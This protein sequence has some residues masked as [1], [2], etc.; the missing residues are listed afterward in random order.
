MKKAIL[1]SII[2]C[3]SFVYAED[4]PFLGFYPDQGTTD[5]LILGWV[6]WN[7]PLAKADIRTGDILLQIDSLKVVNYQD[8]QLIIKRYKPYQN[9]K[10]VIKRGE[11]ILEKTL[12]L[13]NSK[14]ALSHMKTGRKLN[15]YEITPF[16]KGVL[17]I[18]DFSERYLL[19]AINKAGADKDF[20]ILK[21]LFN[22]ELDEK[23]GVYTL[24]TFHFLFKNPLKVAPLAEAIANPFIKTSDLKEIVLLM[25]NLMDEEIIIEKKPEPVLLNSNSLDNNEQDDFSQIE[26]ILDLSYSYREKAFSELTE[27]EISKMKK[28]ARE[29][30]ADLPENIYIHTLEKQQAFI[31]RFQFINLTKK[32]DYKSLILSFIVLTDFSKKDYWLFLSKTKEMTS[33]DLLD[34][35]KGKARIIAKTKSGLVILGG[36]EDNVYDNIDAA[37]IIDLGGNDIYKFNE[38]KNIIIVDMSG[39][40]K[41]YGENISLAS[42]FFGNGGIIDFE[43]ND[44]YSVKQGGL[45]FGY[46]GSGLIYDCNGDDIYNARDFAQ[47]SSLFGLGLL[48]DLSGNDYYNSA[49]YSQ[50]FA[51]PKSIGLLLDKSGND[52]YRATGL[53][54]CSYGVPGLF[55]SFSQGCAMGIRL[56]ASAGIGLLI[57]CSGRDKYYAGNFSQ[58]LGYFLGLGMLYDNEGNDLYDG[59]RYSQGSSAHHAIGILVDKAG[60]DRYIADIAAD[61]GSSWDMSCGYLLDYSGDDMYYSP[62]Y[63]NGGAAQN[64]FGIHLDFSG[65]DVYSAYNNAC[66]YGGDNSYE[67]GRGAKSL[68]IHIDMKGKDY[69]QIKD[70]KNKTFWHGASIGIFW[71]ID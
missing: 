18:D 7:S 67:E 9:V 38:Q 42:G 15:D 16:L 64:A 33:G 70:R 28:T 71:D 19:K 68:G 54:P 22:K 2:C 29:L 62:S 63:T 6:Y 24:N 11:E 36:K 65:N 21:K 34:N 4:R 27:E 31:D 61:Q 8:F 66:G 51:G 40:D 50:G 23:R 48:I 26:K 12:Q 45:G 5:K 3:I 10:L 55:Q 30:L 46:L 17:S 35:I 69:Y 14:D 20:D 25:S 52:T 44:E 47:G 60:N 56:Y 41:Y 32:V 37:M 43:G 57:D 58:G 49:I 53:Y 59:S 13:G 39:N 1:I